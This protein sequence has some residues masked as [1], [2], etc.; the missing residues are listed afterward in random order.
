MGRSGDVS[1]CGP[2]RNENFGSSRS[3]EW[4]ESIPPKGLGFLG[5]VRQPRVSR[6]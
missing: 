5:N 1:S 4:W 2:Y 6:S 3:K